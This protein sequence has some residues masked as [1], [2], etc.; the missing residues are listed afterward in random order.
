MLRETKKM[1]DLPYCSGLKPNHSISEAC[2]Y[3]IS[4]RYL[5]SPQHFLKFC[6]Y[7]A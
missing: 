2:L 6:V 1:H 3:T 7:T 4:V 5:Q